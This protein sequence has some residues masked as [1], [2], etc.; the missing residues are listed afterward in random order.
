MDSLTLLWQTTGLFH[1]T[2]GSLFMVGVGGGVLAVAIAREFEPVFLFALGFSIILTHMPGS[3]M[4][5]PGGLLSLLYEGGVKNGLLPGLLFLGLGILTDFGPLIAMPSLLLVGM[6][7]QTG[8]FLT[9]LAA[10]AVSAGFG[11]PFS[12][13]DAA[14]I[15]MIGGAHPASVIFCADRLAPDLLG[16]IV[17]ALYAGMAVLPPLQSSIVR[18][19]TT[20]QE[21]QVVM[22][23]LRPVSRWEK[24][25]FPL[26][27][28]LPCLLFLP[29][30]APLLGL[31]AFGN[32]LR[33]SG[34]LARITIGLE[35]TTQA[36]M[37]SIIS[38]LFGLAVGSRLSA[39]GFFSLATL[40][41]FGLAVLALGVGSAAGVLVS[42]G[43]QRIGR[44][45][46][47]PL[48]G[49]AGVAA[50]PLTAR[51]VGKLWAEASPDNR[52]SHPFLL[53]C[54]MGANMAGVVGSVLAAGI[55]LAV[56]G[57]G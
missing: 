26:V 13:T 36:G 6:A 20:E 42:K 3:T 40:G 55:L 51:M 16:S 46:V 30:I 56:L 23:P 27:L 32:L 25:L 28:L 41:I 57:G 2:W 43:L 52:L 4:A 24:M 47:N 31:L 1:L 9:L 48:V 5:E 22:P 33:E 19:L 53:A 8:I 15:G 14:A 29:V 7:A 12:L 21:R 38:L 35:Q 39:E 18:L 11:S 45:V 34:L 50:V 37:L 49:V 44:G 54:A 10:L 17:V